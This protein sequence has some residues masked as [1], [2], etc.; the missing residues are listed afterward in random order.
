MVMQAGYEIRRPWLTKYEKL[1]YSMEMTFKAVH[2]KN[3]KSSL[4]CSGRLNG[5]SLFAALIFH[6]LMRVRK[7]VEYM[8]K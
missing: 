2:S 6:T 7:T 5:S 1:A 8:L 4:C 3:G